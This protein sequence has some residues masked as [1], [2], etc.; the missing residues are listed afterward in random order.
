MKTFLKILFATIALCLTAAT[1]KAD[2]NEKYF[3]KIG[4]KS[5][6]SYSY[7]SPLMLKAMADQYMSDKAYG[8]LP[9][10]TSSLN[11]IESL[12]TATEGQDEKLWETIRKVKKD[13]KLET[14]STKKQDYYRYD[15]LA[16]LSGDS[17]YITNLMVITQ[18]GGEA[19][20]VVYMEGKIPLESLKYHLN[21]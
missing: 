15:M 13:K 2:N 9:I 12:S 17:K 3:D 11:M 14:L 6:F 8:S 5:G 7:I 21:N 19:V 16:R 4:G 20:D 1:A 18:N 10:R